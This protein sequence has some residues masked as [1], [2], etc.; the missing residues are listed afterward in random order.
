[1]G[2]LRITEALSPFPF[3]FF[4][5]VTGLETEEPKPKEL[6][7]GFLGGGTTVDDDVSSV[8][9]SEEGSWNLIEKFLRVGWEW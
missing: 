4:L 8:D 9:L 1:M 2:S 5:D 7:L 6:E 3:C